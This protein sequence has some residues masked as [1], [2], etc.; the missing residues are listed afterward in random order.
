M[1]L[2]N[3]SAETLALHGGTW[4]AD[5]V[6]GAVAVPIYIPP[7][8]QFH[9]PPCGPAVRAGRYRHI[10][11]VS[12]TPPGPFETRIAA[13]EGGRG[14]AS[15]VV[16]AGQPSAY[17]VLNL[18]APATTSSPPPTTRRHLGLFAPR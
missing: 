16:G 11:T 15:A 18:A 1:T 2:E 9:T 10:Y 7:S 13:Q 3:R 6:S 17:S 5:P 4:R 8:Y 14:R 12:P